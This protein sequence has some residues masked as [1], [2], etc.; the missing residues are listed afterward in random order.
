M[1]HTTTLILALTISLATVGQTQLD[2]IAVTFGQQEMHDGNQIFTFGYIE[3]QGDPLFVPGPILY[4]NEGDSVIIDMWNLSQNDHT[5]HLHGMDVDQINDG[6]PQFSYTIEPS[7]HG[8]YHLRAPHAGTYIYHCHYASSVHF[9]GGMYGVVV[10]KPADGSDSTWA[11]GFAYDN[12]IILLATEMA[13]DWHTFDILNQDHDPGGGLHIDLPP[14]H[15]EYFLVN[16]F[17]GTQL[18][19]N[20]VGVFAENGEV[21]HLRLNNMGY[22]VT[23]WIFPEDLNAVIV[24]SDGRPLPTYEATDTV[25]VYPGE[26]YDIIAEPSVVF[27]GEI[28]VDYVNMNT[29]IIEDTQTLEVDITTPTGM[30]EVVV[31]D[32]IGLSVYPNPVS[33]AT[34]ISFELKNS[35]DL[36][37]ELFDVNGKR[38]EVITESAF[39]KGKYVL[40][41]SPTDHEAGNYVLRIIAGSK[42][43]SETRVTLI[44]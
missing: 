20:Q 22:Y 43:L 34:T 37:I 12:D 11:G 28:T 40:A 27:T 39:N 25:W 36:S 17:S 8:Y 35:E 33:E 6:V 42:Q 32:P 1:R 23:R 41:W 44:D 19:A 4:M 7:T 18:A 38:V 24:A 15:P 5:V 21:N 13:A 26:R 29:G 10:V 3:N 31:D 2:L 30:N 16:G 14:Y 9:Q